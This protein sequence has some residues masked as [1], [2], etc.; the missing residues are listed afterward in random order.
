MAK[1]FHF[2]DFKKNPSFGNELDIAE[3]NAQD[4]GLVRSQSIDHSLLQTSEVFGKSDWNNQELSDLYR[5]KQ[6]LEKAGIQIMTDRGT[7]D[8][9][10]PW[11]VFCQSNGEVFVHLCRFDGI[12]LLDSPNIGTPLTGYNF[13]ELI[14]GFVQRTVKLQTGEN[15][16]QLHAKNRLNLHPAIMLT[17]LIWSLYLASDEL[18]DIAHAEELMLSEIDF[19]EI[20]APQVADFNFEEM[21]EVSIEDADATSRQQVLNSDGEDGQKTLDTRV[22]QNNMV[23][24]SVALSLA[25]I[26][27]TYG[28]TQY[29]SLV[30]EANGEKSAQ[31]VQGLPQAESTQVVAEN[32][33]A[34][35]KNARVSDDT[36]AADHQQVAKV[37]GKN[38][39]L[40]L[41]QGLEAKSDSI[42]LDQLIVAFGL[43]SAASASIETVTASLASDVRTALQVEDTQPLA[44]EEVAVVQ[45]EEQSSSEPALLDDF[46][47]SIMV[48]HAEDF[49]EQKI[50]QQPVV[51]AEIS[52]GE[53][54]NVVD[55]LKPLNIISDVSNEGEPSKFL[56][57]NPVLTQY[58]SGYGYA[59]SN[60]NDIVVVGFSVED[61]FDNIYT[62][63]DQVI[64]A[65]FLDQQTTGD[66]YA[67]RDDQVKE[68]SDG[69]YANFDKM[70]SGSGLASDDMPVQSFFNLGSQENG[71][72]DYVLF[73]VGEVVEVSEILKNGVFFDM[74][75]FDDAENLS[76]ARS[77]VFEDSDGGLQQAILVVSIGTMLNEMDSVEDN[78][79]VVGDGNASFFGHD[80]FAIV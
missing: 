60:V 73:N 24:Q 13:K 53:I 19:S 29:V 32:H 36:V 76:Y 48:E 8:E 14:D 78:V 66:V 80:M 26:A 68:L 17:A 21:S 39:P 71:A 46:D 3:L 61:Q 16:V 40:Q 35:D 25:T 12:Y 59:V 51:V 49:L 5:V 56:H 62:T 38:T 2:D 33:L 27:A 28:F 69:I 72:S 79:D 67:S 45:L 44:E 74:T 43:T 37:A 23:A 15:V 42:Q 63:I 31:D 65:N 64:S 70:I 30:L 34:T 7:S 22:A 47:T 11:F 4:M 20:L 6:L 57:I 58:M 41:V 54:P 52:D 75:P 10:D 50:E 1:I 77:W 9:G 55:I 18:V